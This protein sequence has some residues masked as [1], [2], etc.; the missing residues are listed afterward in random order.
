MEFLIFGKTMEF[1]SMEK[2]WEKDTQ[3]GLTPCKP[4]FKV[5]VFSITITIT[6]IVSNY[7]YNRYHESYV[8]QFDFT[9]LLF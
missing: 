6:V 2:Q 9:L 5:I 3:T 1:L 8:I 7:T 4:C